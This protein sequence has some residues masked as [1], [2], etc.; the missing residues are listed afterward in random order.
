MPLESPGSNI[1]LDDDNINTPVEA[2]EMCAPLNSMNFS[3]DKASKSLT[4]RN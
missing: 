1:L 4:D 3:V 2:A